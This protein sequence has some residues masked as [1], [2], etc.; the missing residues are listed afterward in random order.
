MCMLPPEMLC[1][2]CICTF[3]ERDLNFSGPV[4]RK[5]VRGFGLFPLFLDSFV[6]WLLLSNLSVCLWQILLMIFLSLP[7]YDWAEILT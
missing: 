1:S 3:P 4:S 2:G 6:L 7:E 5:G